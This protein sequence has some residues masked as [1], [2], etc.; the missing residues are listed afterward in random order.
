[1]KNTSFI[2]PVLDNRV[3]LAKRAIASAQLNNFGE[4][5]IVG[6]RELGS[7]LPFDDLIF[8]RDEG[9]LA[10]RYNVGVNFASK[11]YIMLLND[12]D[13]HLTIPQVYRESNEDFIFSDYYVLFDTKLEKA[14]ASNGTAFENGNGIG[15]LTVRI[16]S[17]ILKE[18]AFDETLLYAEDYDMW[19][20]LKTKSIPQTY[21]PCAFAVYNHESTIH[22]ESSPEYA[23]RNGKE[24]AKISR[25]YI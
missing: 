18:N 10:H 14:N 11:G 1:M 17:D 4:I 24:V 20:K 12:D 25:R 15:Y 22:R 7:K 6:S 19:L 3:N 16:K 2:L 8:I 13:F 21:I 23:E 9:N 5:I